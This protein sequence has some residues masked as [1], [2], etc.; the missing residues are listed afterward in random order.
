M[1]PRIIIAILTLYAFPA[2]PHAEAYGDSVT[3][4]E[5]SDQLHDIRQAQR[6]AEHVA[7]ASVALSVVGGTLIGIGVVSDTPILAM[8]GGAV[9]IAATF[10]VVTWTDLW[11]T[12]RGRPKREPD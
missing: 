8:A 3:L 12:A 1:M 7:R 11:H 9:D 4:T 2:L 5:I 6:H 10:V